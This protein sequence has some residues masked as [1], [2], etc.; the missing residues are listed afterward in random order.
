LAPGTLAGQGSSKEESGNNFPR[1]GMETMGVRK[2]PKLLQVV[3]KQFSPRGDGNLMLKVA[4]AEFEG[5]VWKQ[6]SPRG[7][8]NQKLVPAF[9]MFTTLVWKCFSP[10]EDESEKI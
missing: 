5:I 2:Q 1:E 9:L 8:G 10:R 4:F 3:W 7:N 6:F